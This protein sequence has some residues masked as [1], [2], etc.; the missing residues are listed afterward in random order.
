MSEVTRYSGINVEWPKNQG[1]YTW[2]SLPFKR[3]PSS[4]QN[5]PDPNADQSRNSVSETYARNSPFSRMA[6]GQFGGFKEVGSLHRKRAFTA[7]CTSQTAAN[8]PDQT[9]GQRGHPHQRH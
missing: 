2:F 6:C 1:L 8:T 3:D 7:R 5:R 4:K 9:E